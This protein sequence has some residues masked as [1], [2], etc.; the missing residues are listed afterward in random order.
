MKYAHSMM[1]IVLAMAFIANSLNFAGPAFA[2][3]DPPLNG[4]MANFTLAETAKEA[5]EI[6]FTTADGVRYNLSQWK[7]KVVLLNFWATWCAPCRREMPA[8]DALQAGI[9]SDK[10]E[11]IALSSD[12]KGLD[13]VQPFFDKIGIKH[14]EI[15]LDPTLKSQRAFRV[16]G[17]P[18]TVLID[19]E[20]MIVGRLAGPAEWNNQDAKA[21]IRHYL[22]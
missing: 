22:N 20:G 9:G 8:L 16:I 17:L 12:R 2:G 18:T 5:P 1:K 13:Q 3:G 6:S 10:F 15:Y 21:L 14:L 19:R 7:G 4:A 11:I